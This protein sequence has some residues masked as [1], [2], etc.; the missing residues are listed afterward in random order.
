MTVL[1][2]PHAGAGPSVF[3][4]WAL[5][6]PEPV[7][8]LP[9]QLPGREARREEPIPTEVPELA[10]ALLEGL[11]PALHRPYA[12]FGHSMGAILA[13]ELARRIEKSRLP[14]PLHLFVAA[15]G[16]PHAYRSPSQVHL[17][18]RRELI[19]ELR[20]RQGTPEAVLANSELMG[21]YIPILRADLAL[22]ASYRHHHEGALA[23]PISAFAGEDDRDPPPDA[24]AAWAGL[25][26]GAF[27]FRLL[28]GNHSFP[29]TARPVLLEAIRSD[30]FGDGGA[31]RA[32]VA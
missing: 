32:T 20:R 22:C 25:T 12:L 10:D 23:T 16:A 13:F 11:E 5:E 4:P 26:T 15:Y 18:P 24:V 27:K 6:A 31:R 1:C 17:L 19:E 9:L 14:K 2:I 21:Y 3:R 29:S 8:I 7:E 28:P 30:L